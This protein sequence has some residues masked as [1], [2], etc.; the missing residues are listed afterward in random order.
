MKQT[1]LIFFFVLVSFLTLQAQEKNLADSVSNL[2]KK[3][4]DLEGK[5]RTAYKQVSDSLQES[6]SR[7]RTIRQEV[8]TSTSMVKNLTVKDLLNAQEK[9]NT[10]TESIR[11]TAN[12]LDAANKSL[13]SIELS[14]QISG[15]LNLI[16]ELNNPTNEDLGFSLDK[17]MQRLIEEKIIKGNRKFNNKNPGKFMRFVSSVIK[18]PITNLIASSV[19]AVSSL[20]TVFNVVT[21]TAVSEPSVNSGDLLAFQ[22][23]VKKYIE[24]YEKLAMASDELNVNLQTLKVKTQALK[25]LVKDFTSEL[26]LD[27]H[28]NDKADAIKTLPINKLIERYY[29][30]AVVD[31][32]IKK[33]E[34]KFSNNYERLSKE[35]SLQYSIV[36]RNKVEFIAQELEKLSSEYLGMLQNFHTQILDVIKNADKLSK[37]KIKISQKT[38]QL[39]TQYKTVKESFKNAVDLS[40]IRSRLSDM[41]RY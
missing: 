24:H 35:A 16:T 34:A 1:R 9:Y 41:P 36:G 7:Y 26:V 38:K 37:E 30:Y 23:E 4:L 15:Y 29:N 22:N 33:A 28:G 18:N 27:L 32:Y 6:Y 14:L 8:N 31:N 11:N 39:E 19:P 3:Y 40:T 17:E 21:S 10:N 20:T 2:Y 25:S 12:F 13:S 5:A